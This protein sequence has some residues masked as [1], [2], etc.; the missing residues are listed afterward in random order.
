[1]GKNALSRRSFVKVSAAVLGSAVLPSSIKGRP[2]VSR[3]R[4]GG[5][6][7]TGG[8][9]ERWIANLKALGYR[10]YCPVS[11]DASDDV[12]RAYADAARKADIIIAGLPGAI[13]SVRTR[14]SATPL[15]KHAAINSHWPTGSAPIAASISPARAT[16]P[17]GPA[18]TRT[19]SQRKHS[20]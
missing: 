3:L 14:P 9:P 11:A 13:L 17:T 12:V 8:S 20:R 4:L 1:M 16:P 10:A 5:P 7:S 18:R 6:C 19:I 15:S 2:T